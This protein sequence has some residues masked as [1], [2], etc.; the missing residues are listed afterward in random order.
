L[1]E[2]LSSLRKFDKFIINSSKFYF[3][4]YSQVILVYF[5]LKFVSF[6]SSKL[7]D[8]V[9]PAPLRTS[10]EVATFVLLV[11]ACL[12]KLTPLECL[13][14]CVCQSSHQRWA[15]W[16]C[17][18][19]TCGQDFRRPCFYSRF[20]W[21]FLPIGE[22]FGLINSDFAWHIHITDP[23]AEGD[24]NSRWVNLW[25]GVAD[26]DHEG[27]DMREINVALS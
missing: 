13:L 17:C 3:V 5:Y 7:L 24:D 21:T 4:M 16:P 2:F 6:S 1:F 25:D 19:P 15:Q 12:V 8:V 11:I 18:R 20:G 26:V 10:L 27:D 22:H 23:V 14:V 9:L